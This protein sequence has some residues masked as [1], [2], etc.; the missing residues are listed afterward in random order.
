MAEYVLEIRHVDVSR[1]T[2]AD[3]LSRLVGPDK[4][5]DEEEKKNIERFLGKDAGE[6]FYPGERTIVMTDKTSIEPT[7]DVIK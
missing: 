5:E 1:N 7:L 6:R 4:S 3:C 2:F